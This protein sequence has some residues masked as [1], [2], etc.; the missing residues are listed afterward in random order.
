VFFI[1]ITLAIGQMFYA[2]FFKARAFGGDNGMAGTPRFDLSPIGLE[3]GDP[4]V[5]SALLL[6]IA[7]AGYCAP[8][9]P[10]RRKL[11]R[12]WP[13]APAPLSA[14]ELPPD[15][16]RRPAAETGLGSGP[17][18]QLGREVEPSEAVLISAECEGKEAKI[19][20]C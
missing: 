3:A 4:A 20:G 16:N 18:R 9:L 10:G 19:V 15:P 2:Y 11:R 1:M 17:G 14:G 5:F 12:R 13:L 8:L 6:G 7:A